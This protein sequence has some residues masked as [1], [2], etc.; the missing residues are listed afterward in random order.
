MR[1]LSAAFLYFLIVFAVGFLLGP[2][3]VF[4]LEPKLGET[5]AVLCESPFLIVAI[6]L[7]AR[8]LPSALSLRMDV[9]S[10]ASMGLGALVFQQLA[11]FGVGGLLRGMSLRQQLAR[12]TRPAGL[13]Y[14]AVVIVFAA[15]PILANLPNLRLVQAGTFGA[16]LAGR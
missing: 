8:W 12:L 11:D 16:V 9:V 6:I 5:R 4:W 10:L 1:I 7:A 2:L 3:R 13:I 15:M 14:I